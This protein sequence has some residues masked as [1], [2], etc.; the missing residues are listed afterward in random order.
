MIKV[1]QGNIHRSW[2]ANQLK[3]KYQIQ[4]EIEADL[5]II[6]EQYPMAN[7]NPTTWFGDEHGTA[8]I[9]VANPG[10]V[11]VEA[12]GRGRGFVRVRSNNITY[13]SCYLTPNRPIQYYYTKLEDIEYFASVMG[14]SRG[15][16]IIVAGGIN[17]KAV[18]WGM[19]YTDSK[20]EATLETMSRLGLVVLNVGNTTTF[21][22]ASYTQTIID[23]TLASEGLST[24]V[25]NWHVM[26]VFTASNH[27][28]ISFEI[29]HERQPPGEAHRSKPRGWNLNNLNKE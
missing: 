17:A 26:E 16:S 7:T 4:R 2:T 8:A 10:K 18:D 5:W 22:R 9:W 13:V 23:V 24:R 19:P 1:A 25:N 6:S 11:S 21:R 27:R 15:N 29:R 3:S 20:G 28:Y 12:S 14:N